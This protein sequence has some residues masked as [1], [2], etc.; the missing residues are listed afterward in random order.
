MTFIIL[1]FTT[2]RNSSLTDRISRGMI[3]L[4][5]LCFP[6]VI[7]LVAH[8]NHD[9]PSSSQTLAF[10]LR[11]EINTTLLVQDLQSIIALVI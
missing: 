1:S 10:I 8:N 11:F 2:I 5:L 6:E 4:K 9:L 3:P 7:Y